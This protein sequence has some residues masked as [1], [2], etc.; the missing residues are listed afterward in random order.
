MSLQG[1]YPLGIRG[2]RSFYLEAWNGNSSFDTDRI[3][4][5]SI[6]IPNLCVSI[7]GGI[8]PDKLTLYLEQSANALANDGM[9]QRFQVLLYPDHRSWE[10]IDRIPNKNVRDRV[11]EMFDLIADCDPIVWG[12]NQSD[13]FVKFPYFCF[14]PEAQNIFIK[15]SNDLHKIKLTTEDN[16]LMAQHLAKYDKLFPAL[17]LI[18]HL[19]DCAV[20]RQWGAVR[21]QSAR[22]AAEWCKF[23]EAHARRCYGLLSDEGL[24]SAQALAKKLTEGKL[25][26]EFTAR[27][28]R[29]NNWRYLTTDISVQAALDWLEDEEWLRSFEVGGSGPGTGRRTSRYLINPEIQKVEKSD[30]PIEQH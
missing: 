4:R 30:E 29:R 10:W 22:R 15:F 14:E 20:T 19:I 28:I 24:R 16:P 12:A 23:L 5:G 8:Q 6:F 21:E 1:C 2:D 9:L 7:F 11:Y 27:D 3:G 13:D 25:S 26:N 17:A 18:F